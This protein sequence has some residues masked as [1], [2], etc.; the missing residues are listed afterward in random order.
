MPFRNAL[1]PKGKTPTVAAVEVLE[2]ITRTGKVGE[3]KM[4]HSTTLAKSVGGMTSEKVLREAVRSMDMLSQSGLPQI[5]AMA[6][7]ALLMLEHPNQ[8]LYQASLVQLL[9]AISEQAQSMEDTINSV[10]EDVG[11]NYQAKPFGGM[12]GDMH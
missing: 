9:K 8:Q 11:A 12:V 6:E 10:A 1:T 3:I 7:G 2:V 4:N 5:A